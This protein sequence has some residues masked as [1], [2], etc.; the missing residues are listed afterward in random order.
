MSVFR[1]FLFSIL[2]LGFE[3]ISA[4]ETDSMVWW[5]PTNSSF[6][7]VQGQAWPDQV[8]GT[9]HRLPE[10][11]ENTVRPAVWNLSKDAAGLSIRFW[12][13]ARSISVRY[14]VK[15]SHA[16]PHMP[17]TGVSGVDL[18]AKSS[19]GE[20]QWYRGRYSFG[21]TIHYHYNSIDPREKYHEK[22]REY[23][24]Y[25][26]LYN[27]VEWLEIG[28]SPESD[29]NPLPLRQERPIVIYGTS[30]AQGGCASR[31]GMAW[32]SILERKLDRPL[33]NLGFSGNG[34][35]ES[36]LID[37]I[38]EIDAKV[39]VL[40]CLPNLVA[41]KNRSL[42][43]VLQLMK[44]AVF[45]I[46]EK[47]PKVPILLVE[48]GG[49]SD[50]LVDVERK[51]A[52]TDLNRMAQQAF[53]QLQVAGVS[54]LYLLG[55]EEINLSMESFVDGT[56]PTDLGMME[57][58]LAYEKKI[59]EI[60]K[61]PIG[62]YSTTKPVTQAREPGMYSWEE[63]HQKLIQLNRENPPKVCFLGNSIVHYWGGLPEAPRS[64]G[65]QSWEDNFG[66]FKTRNFG[67]GWDRIE[68]V[69]WRVYQGELDG[70]EADQIVLMIG[71]NNLH[72]NSDKEILVGLEI[73]VQAIRQRQPKA[74][75]LLVGFLP[76]VKDEFRIRNLNL[77]IAKLA[78][79]NTLKYVDV[80]P[81]LLQKD[82]KIDATLFSD[83]LHPNDK[84][85]SL[86]GRE[87]RKYIMPNSGH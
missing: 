58:A 77:E 87:L 42:E 29:L 69:L 81:V 15:G 73:L 50:G 45:K 57:Y 5:N 49:Y 35:L 52:Y 27:E 18:Y 11:S 84:G 74:K 82:Q 36:E 61:E 51:K 67:F 20:S 76:R 13:D 34:R 6:P 38:T 79:S 41:T 70:F 64:N 46:R 3:N 43:E 48:H 4:Q 10:K 63:R 80:G 14:T 71:T 78:S 59:R 9:Y 62:I 68:N 23:Q 47:R 28:V 25:L 54:N 37:L 2:F 56:H 72:L 39:V 26:P 85:Y 7:V 17:A 40:D 24:L 19:D 16:M 31:P 66:D 75:L 44:S 12:S 33:I 60:L 30:I 65:E 32:T 21:D 53:N 55:K 83:G 22:G 86:L 1:I 8:A